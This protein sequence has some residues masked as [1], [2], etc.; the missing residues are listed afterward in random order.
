MIL[1]TALIHLKM[2][3][4]PYITLVIWALAAGVVCVLVIPYVFMSS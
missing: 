1:I 2:N 4:A 3:V